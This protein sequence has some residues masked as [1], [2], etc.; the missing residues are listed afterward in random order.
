MNPQKI[1]PEIAFVNKSVDLSSKGST[2]DFEVSADHMQALWSSRY[3]DRLFV[4]AS[5]S[6][7]IGNKAYIQIVNV[8]TGQTFI[9]QEVELKSSNTAAGR[10]TFTLIRFPTSYRVIQ[11]TPN[12][13]SSSSGDFWLDGIS[14]AES[15]SLMKPLAIHQNSD[16]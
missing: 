6:K 14:E 5:D 16:Y 9:S 13:L 2:V 1:A 4:H 10:L 7:S 11:V 15:K 3:V 12:N 8:E